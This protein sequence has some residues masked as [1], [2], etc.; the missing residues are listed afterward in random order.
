MLG[1]LGLDVPGVGP[2][3][4]A[5][6]CP[7]GPRP[8]YDACAPYGHRGHGHHAHH[9]HRR[10]HRSSWAAFRRYLTP[11][12]SALR[13]YYVR[14]YFL[15]RYPHLF[16]KHEPKAGTEIGTSSFLHPKYD[17]VST[18]RTPRQ[19]LNYAMWQLH[20]G[21]YKGART[22][23]GSVKADTEVGA[24]A[25]FGRLVSALALSSWRDAAADLA[26]LHRRELL[27]PGDRLDAEGLFGDKKKLANMT[28]TVRTFVR[29]NPQEADGLLAG[30]WLHAVQGET[31]LARAYLQRAVRL[32]PTR[33]VA[34]ALLE[35]VTPKPAKTP[36]PATKP[37]PTV[38]PSDVP[39]D[40]AW[41]GPV[42]GQPRP[43]VPHAARQGR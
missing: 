22:T 6:E 12:G 32:D 27:K 7:C 24:Q 40:G 29:W 16:A 26:T 42:A 13:Y 41:Y 34:Q 28:T 36:D 2:V 3:A 39:S 20:L 4:A 35:Q 5:D 21:N 30:G 38:K 9:G 33:R 43:G 25:A 1:L 37:A 14:A 23:F 11:S 15:R 19:S 18:P 10:I 17:V 8:V 31:R